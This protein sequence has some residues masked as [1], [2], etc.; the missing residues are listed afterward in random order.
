MRNVYTVY[1]RTTGKNNCYENNNEV[2][3]GIVG[4]AVR[5]VSLEEYTRAHTLAF[6]LASMRTTT[7][8]LLL[9]FFV[10]VFEITRP[11]ERRRRSRTISASTV[12][13]VRPS[14]DDGSRPSDFGKTFR[15]RRKKLSFCPL[16]ARQ[17]FA[18]VLPKTRRRHVLEH[19]PVVRK[20][21][22]ATRPFRMSS[23]TLTRP[24]KE[25]VHRTI[26][27]ERTVALVSFAEF[28]KRKKRVF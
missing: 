23:A 4:H 12:N 9:L 8:L 13:R 21:S 10:V 1:K 24:T 18:P 6:T 19:L 17:W 3:T 22:T 27:Q 7:I 28:R 2:T 15:V 5:Q 25:R 26:V 16:D 11:S 20:S 14:G